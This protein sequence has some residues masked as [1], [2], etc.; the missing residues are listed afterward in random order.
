MKPAS[1]AKPYV[2]SLPEYVPGKPIDDV[3]RD[4]GLDPSG[5]I[6]LAS[7]ENAFGPSPLAAAA[8]RRAIGQ[9]QLYPDGECFAL[10]A[11]LAQFHGLSPRQFV[12]GN[13]SNEV[14]ELLGHVFLGP[15]DEVVMGQPEFVVYRLMTLL[16][17]ARPVEV[18]L[19]NF[20]NDLTALARAVTPRT[21][22]VIVST[23]NNPTGTATPAAEL[24][25]FIRSLPGTAI[26][27]VDEAYTDFAE[28]AP[29]IRP[30]LGEGCNVIGLRTFSKV[31]GLASLRV[32][33][34]YTTPE[35]ASLLDR[36]RQPF[37]VNAIGQAAAV[38]A[39]DDREF[40]RMCVAETRK[41][42]RRLEGGCGALGLAYVPSEANFLLVRVGDGAKVFDA[43]LKRG[44][45]VRPLKQYSLP[46]WIRV[47]AGTAE[48]NERFLRELAAV[49]R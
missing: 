2:L 49:V 22:L 34:G 42:L 26:C 18:P 4:L 39:L 1:L 21:K 44:V 28:G 30:L 27:V 9:G 20:R 36:V 23:P 11:K 47:T 10:R 41:G 3:A 48:Q 38:A 16:F 8:A 14:I 33:Y 43:L 32:G 6:K 37:N 25:A 24:L 12:I 46:E 15:G 13:G 19:V 17:G 31:Y 7:N 5:I 45:I 35:L 29:D 40:T